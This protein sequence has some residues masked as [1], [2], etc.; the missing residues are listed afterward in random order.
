MKIVEKGQ[1]PYLDIPY[2][3][4]LILRASDELGVVGTP[5]S[6]GN[7]IFMFSQSMQ[8]APVAR[9]VDK[10]G[11][12]LACSDQ[13]GAIVREIAEPHFIRMPSEV[14]TH[15]QGEVVPV[16]HVITIE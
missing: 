8:Y 1:I 13:L 3:C 16:A 6:E 5:A 2:P 10:H 9:V 12:V 15:F 14:D 4:L 11:A 7:P